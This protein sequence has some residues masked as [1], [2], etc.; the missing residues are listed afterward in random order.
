[1]SAT[2]SSLVVP[3][4][5]DTSTAI[6]FRVLRAPTPEILNSLSLAV[7]AERI[8]LTYD[9]TS[10]DHLFRGVIPAAVAGLADPALGTLVFSVDST[11]SLKAV[12]EGDD[13]RGVGCSFDW[14]ELRPVGGVTP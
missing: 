9:N 4:P 1:M 3:L 13:S 2:R 12:G 14:L 11:T 7:N 6:E 8:G 10:G 5:A